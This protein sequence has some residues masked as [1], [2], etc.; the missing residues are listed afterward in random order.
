MVLITH[1]LWQRRFGGARD[2][3][4][5]QIII[6]GAPRESLALFRNK[7]DFRVW[8]KFI[9]HWMNFAPKT[10]FFAAA[11]IPVFPCLAD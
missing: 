5:Q 11:I 10:V 7:S 8:L 4:G 9:C 3:L 2:V 1:G 6:D